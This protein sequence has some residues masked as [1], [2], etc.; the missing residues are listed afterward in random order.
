M[1]YRGSLVCCLLLSACQSTPVSAP[2]QGH[3]QF[4]RAE[5]IIY[6]SAGQVVEKITQA[7][8]QAAERSLDI[9]AH[10][11]ISHQVQ[12]DKVYPGDSTYTVTR[13]Y[14]QRNGT[15]FV[16]PAPG[17]EARP[18]SIRQLTANRLVLQSLPTSTPGGLHYEWNQYSTR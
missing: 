5:Q 18:V 15:L 12:T 13:S 2:L 16:V 7:P 1:S 3:W 17:I 14:T 8:P 6:S 11:L 4:Q 10:A 9:T